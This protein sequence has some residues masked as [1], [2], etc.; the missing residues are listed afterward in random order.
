MYDSGVILKGK[1]EASHKKEKS[2][3]SCSKTAKLK[4]P[5]PKEN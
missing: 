4:L 2:Q 5:H 3:G 1:L